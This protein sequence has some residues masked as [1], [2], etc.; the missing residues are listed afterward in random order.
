MNKQSLQFTGLAKGI[1]GG[2]TMQKNILNSDA[3]SES[4]K[5]QRELASKQAERISKI[6]FTQPKLSTIVSGIATRGNTKSV[7]KQAF[8]LPDTRG[9][10]IVSEFCAIL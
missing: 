9:L 4:F 2:F 7:I 6:S 10:T 3:L 1:D 5:K 8:L